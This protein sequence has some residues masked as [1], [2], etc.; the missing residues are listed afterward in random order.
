MSLNKKLISEI[1]MGKKLKVDPVTQAIEIKNIMPTVRPEGF[2]LSQFAFNA[3]A[4]VDESEVLGCG[5]DMLDETIAREKAISEVIERAVLALTARSLKRKI[6]SN[7]W[8]AHTSVEDA[9]LAAV[10]ELIERDSALT[11]WLTKTPMQKLS[12]VESLPKAFLEQLRRSEF[13]EIINLVS[14]DFSGPLVTTLL[15]NSS[16]HVIAGHASG[17]TMENAIASSTIEACRAA[18]HFQRFEYYEETKAMLSGAM[19]REIAPGMHSLMYA[20]HEPLPTWIMGNTVDFSEVRQNWS[21]T[22]NAVADIVASSKFSAF[23]TGSRFVV[24]AENDALQSVFWGPTEKAILDSNINWNR[25]EKNNTNL[26]P[27]MVG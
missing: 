27:H 26:R 20:Y 10:Y 5:E 19:P 7:G 16:G 11:H 8:A 9:A 1:L 12:N 22:T 25:I 18:H 21:S 14:F 17:E 13:P 23:S 2:R 4:K 3:F 15:R 24:R 6:S